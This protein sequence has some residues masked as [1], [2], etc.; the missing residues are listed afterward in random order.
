MH[1]SD[2]VT[3]LALCVVECISCY[4]FRSIPCYEFDGLYNAV[5]YFVLNSRILSFS[6]FANQHGVNVVIGSFEA[7]N[8]ETRP[9]ISKEVKCSSK[10]KVQRNMSLSD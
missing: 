2:S 1:S 8:G 5:H 7:R 10:C 6:V 9:N 3:A 4:T